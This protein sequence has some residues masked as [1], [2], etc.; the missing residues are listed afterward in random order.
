MQGETALIREIKKRF[1]AAGSCSSPRTSVSKGVTSK[2]VQSLPQC[3][4]AWPL[5]IGGEKLSFSVLRIKPVGVVKK[6]K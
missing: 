4:C 5:G 1:A 2:I 3:A 6:C